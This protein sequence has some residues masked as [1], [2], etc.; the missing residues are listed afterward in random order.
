MAA[1]TRDEIVAV[2]GP[3][4]DILIADIVRMG[5]T[6]E[7]VAMARGWAYCDEALANEGRPPPT[8]R[9]ARIAE[10][11]APPPEDDGPAPQGPA[12]LG[13]S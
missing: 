1:L 11:L 3:V 5:A 4:D 13:E 9:V 7:E 8:G 10:L 6:A 12:G 2:L